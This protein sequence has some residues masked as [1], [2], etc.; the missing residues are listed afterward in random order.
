MYCHLVITITVL[1]NI[2]I[3]NLTKRFT[4]FYIADI[5]LLSKGELTAVTPDPLKGGVKMA[6]VICYLTI[7]LLLVLIIKK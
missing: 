3:K 4:K 7:L 2:V 5:I 1:Y 6:E